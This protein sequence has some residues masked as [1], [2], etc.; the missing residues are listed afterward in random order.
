MLN[1]ILSNRNLALIY[2]QELLT[3]LDDLFRPEEFTPAGDIN[4][5]AFYL[6]YKNRIKNLVY[7]EVEKL[8]ADTRN[9]GNCHLILLKH[10][11]LV[12]IVIETSFKT[13][14]WFY[15]RNHHTA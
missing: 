10:T 12:D 5:Q 1:F 4:P 11:A 14:L 9:H 6:D 3:L 7:R 15:N 13:A 8:K 2:R